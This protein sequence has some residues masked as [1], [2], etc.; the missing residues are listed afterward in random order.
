MDPRYLMA[1][2]EWSHTLFALSSRE[3]DSYGDGVHSRLGIHSLNPNVI[4]IAQVITILRT[5]SSVVQS[6]SMFPKV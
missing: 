3:A 4:L 1:S 6:K 5:L 2:S